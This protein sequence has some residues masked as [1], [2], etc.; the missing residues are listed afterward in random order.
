MD[1][2]SIESLTTGKK[3]TAMLNPENFT[4]TYSNQSGDCEKESE[5][6][7][8]SGKKQNKKIIELTQTF[9]FTLILDGTGAIPTGNEWS[10]TFVQ[11]QLEL[12]QSMLVDYKGDI[13]ATDLLIIQW[14]D[15]F[16]QGQITSLSITCNLFDD[17]GNPLRASI[18]LTFKAYQEWED[19]LEDYKDKS[20]DLTH[21]RTVQAGDTLPLMCYK[22]YKD[23]SYYVQVAKSNQLNSIMDI[24]PGQRLYFPPLKSK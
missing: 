22:I 6:T 4:I 7:T 8:A 11:E 18:P 2:L 1:K 20:P 17:K 13:H 15:Y 21:I 12:L 23:A 19:A 5:T 24:K 9:T 3:F 10:P 16:F 14:G